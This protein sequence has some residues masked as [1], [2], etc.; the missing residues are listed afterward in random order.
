MAVAQNGLQVMNANCR[1]AIVQLLEEAEVEGDEKLC[2][3]GR[4]VALRSAAIPI[5]TVRPTRAGK[6]CAFTSSVESRLAQ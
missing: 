6:L 1:L 2:A 3:L 4:V 5:A